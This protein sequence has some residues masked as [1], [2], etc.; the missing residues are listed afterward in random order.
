MYFA[1]LLLLIL[2]TF[3]FAS[4]ASQPSADK[5][6]VSEIEVEVKHHA[7][8]QSQSELGSQISFRVLASGLQGGGTTNGEWHDS[9]KYR[10]FVQSTNQSTCYFN[11]NVEAKPETCEIEQ[12]K[13]QERNCRIGAESPA[14]RYSCSSKNGWKVVT[15]LKDAKITVPGKGKFTATYIDLLQK[16]EKQASLYRDQEKEIASS[17]DLAKYEAFWLYEG[18]YNTLLIV[19]LEPSKKSVLYGPDGFVTDMACIRK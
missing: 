17:N 9:Y 15:E 6:C 16:D 1:Q 18:G 4:R 2:F 12:L 13:I 5:N 11:I 10:L 8:V 3:S 14:G 19:S 7:A